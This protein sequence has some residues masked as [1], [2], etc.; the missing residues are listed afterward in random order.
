MHLLSRTKCETLVL[1]ALRTSQNTLFNRFQRRNRGMT[2]DRRYSLD[3]RLF[4]KARRRSLA[5]VAFT[6]V[7]SGADAVKLNLMLET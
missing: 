1:G 3:T 5:I 7:P 4:W 2:A 6:I